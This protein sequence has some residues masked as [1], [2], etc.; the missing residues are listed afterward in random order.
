MA[1]NARMALMEIMRMAVD[2]AQFL[3]KSRHF[4]GQTEETHEKVPE[5]P[6][7]KLRFEAHTFCIHVAVLA[8]RQ[9][10]GIQVLMRELR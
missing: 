1:S 6:M 8:L 2:V 3:A 9:L 5:Q 7:R 4:P 10:F